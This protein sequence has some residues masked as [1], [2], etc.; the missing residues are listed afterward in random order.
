V[1]Q[2]NVVR[3]VE[4]ALSADVVDLMGETAGLAREA[5]GP[6]MVAAVPGVFQA[7]GARTRDP[8]GAN[9]IVRAI[10]ETSP[11]ATL[12]N[13]TL[14]V[15]ADPALSNETAD[16]VLAGERAPLAGRVAEHSGA[17]VD[18]ADALVRMTLP[19]ALG[20]LARTV[21]VPLGQEN[22]LRLFREQQPAIDRADPFTQATTG[23]A[24]TQISP[25]GR[26]NR[27]NLWAWVI[28]LVLL[29]VLLYALRSCGLGG[30]EPKTET[31]LPAT[32]PGE[33]A[34]TAT[35]SPPT[36]P[37]EGAPAPQPAAPGEGTAPAPSTQTAPAAPTAPAGTTPPAAPN[38]R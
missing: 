4:D 37:V 19:L 36:A 2:P 6:A 23:A 31:V 20:A 38:E 11:A 28:G 14:A 9:E 12:N 17:A 8:A 22:L 33:P 7:L 3:I 27:N 25:G 32:T 13:P 10:R 35:V 1:D 5:R 34:T 24:M 29:A 21:S 16:R 26:R 15:E 30:T 18:A